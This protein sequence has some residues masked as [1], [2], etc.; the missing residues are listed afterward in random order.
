MEKFDYKSY[1][2]DKLSEWVHDSIS[3]AE[4]SPQ[5]IYDTIKKAV[6]ENYYIYKNQTSRCYE[7]LALLNGN[8]KAILD[9]QLDDS[10]EKQQKLNDCWEEYYYP[11]EYQNNKVKK[12]ILPVEVDMASGE[13]YFQLPDDLLQ[14]VNW[15]EGDE[16]QWEDNGDN[17]FLLRKVTKQIEPDEY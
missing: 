17:S 3:G 8:G 16:L 10:S 6:E 14:Q 12:W 2:L 13:Y 15:N 11:E 5:E 9:K 7:L 4:A 1:S